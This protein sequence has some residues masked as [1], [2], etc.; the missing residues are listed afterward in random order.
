MSKFKRVSID[1][2][3]GSIGHSARCVVVP[4]LSGPHFVRRGGRW[5]VTA[6]SFA[7]L[8][9]ISAPGGLPQVE[10]A[11]VIE[12]PAR[13]QISAMVFMMAQAVLFGAGMLGILLSPLRDEASFYI[14]VMIV[15]SAIASVAIAWE[16][17]PRLQMRY[18]HG[19]GVDHD[20]ISG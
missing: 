13:L 16:I 4:P 10:T 17:A 7:A 9:N 6:A 3:F 5:M 11:T 19:R 12:M 18:W 1:A 2:V 20:F 14:P 15:L 8:G